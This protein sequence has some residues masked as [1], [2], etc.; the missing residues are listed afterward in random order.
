MALSS[1]YFVPNVFAAMPAKPAIAWM[2][3]PTTPNFDLAWDMWWGE[4]GSV[5]KLEENGTIIQ[6]IDVVTNSPQAQK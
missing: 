6:T 4:N 3:D 1:L 2:A 5:A